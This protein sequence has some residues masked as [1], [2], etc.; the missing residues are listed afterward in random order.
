MTRG[1]IRL[2]LSTSSTGSDQ[3]FRLLSDLL[4]SLRDLDPQ[5]VEPN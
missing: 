4:I 5:P 1:Q 3:S 2:S